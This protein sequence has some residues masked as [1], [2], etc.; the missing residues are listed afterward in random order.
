M[1][2][3]FCPGDD[4]LCGV[5]VCV[6]VLSVWC[7]CV[8]VWCLC[9]Y[10]YVCVC[11]HFPECANALV[12]EHTCVCQKSTSSFFPQESSTCVLRQRLSLTWILLS[13]LSYLA[14]EAPGIHLSPSSQHWNYRN[15][16][17]AQFFPSFLRIK[18]R[19]QCSHSSP[20]LTVLAPRSS[21]HNFN[22]RVWLV[23]ANLGSPLMKNSATNYSFSCFPLKFQ[24]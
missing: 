2:P 10:V 9:V 12:C 11:I 14:S 3:L 7:L 13:S 6:C 8:Y 24:S 15:L 1:V 23:P 20:L 17:H 21:C 19:Y 16:P 22:T 4:I 18:L 5:C